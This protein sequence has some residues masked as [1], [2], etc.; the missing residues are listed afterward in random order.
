M[1][2]LDLFCGAGGAAVGYSR[3]G[4]DVLGVDVHPQPHYPFEF[5]QR[6]ALQVLKF[7]ADDSEPFPGAPRFDAIHASPPCQ[8]YSD[9]RTMRGTESYPRLVDDVRELLRATALPWVIENVPGA[10]VAFQDTL[11]GRYGVRLDGPM[12]ELEEDEYGLDRERWFEASFPIPQPLARRRATFRVGV[13][14]GGQPGRAGG[15]DKRVM[16]ID[17]MTRE[18]LNEAIPPA[19]TELIGHQ[20]MQ[21]VLSKVEAT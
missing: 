10:P 7:I 13:Y 17:W 19:Y 12:F 20:L 5:E 16:G 21:H 14:G 4:F 15:R 8:A 2:L 9:L 6:D 3:A 1:R 18:E 11:D